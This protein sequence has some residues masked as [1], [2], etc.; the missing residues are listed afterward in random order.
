M[1]NKKC[2]RCITGKEARFRAYTDIMEID[3]CHSCAAEARRLGISVASL[4]IA[5]Y[6]LNPSKPRACDSLDI[7]NAVA[8]RRFPLFRG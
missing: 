5:D 8:V 3:I 4:A 6:P 2:Q 1:R 7:T